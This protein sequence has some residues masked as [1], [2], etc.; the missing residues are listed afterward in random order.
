MKLLA[1][2]SFLLS[3]SL[4]PMELVPF[5]EKENSFIHE[6]RDEQLLHDYKHT[7]SNHIVDKL[8]LVSCITL[9]PK[10]AQDKIIGY[11]AA[12]SVHGWKKK[13]NTQEQEIRLYQ[14]KI[15]L[16]QEKIHQL[17][18]KTHQ[19]SYVIKCNLDSCV[20]TLQGAA[21]GGCCGALSGMA[22]MC[23]YG[24]IEG[25]KMCCCNIF[26]SKIMCTVLGWGLPTC[27]CGGCVIGS[28]CVVTGLHKKIRIL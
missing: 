9:L 25:Y 15:D 3:S 11:M 23:S 19:D 22:V 8:L 4:Y 18:G 16:L 5:L 21:A 24:L 12:D 13:R 7:N 1:I 26:P 14:K 28:C 10:E 27:A 20:N 17:T 2:A 6:K